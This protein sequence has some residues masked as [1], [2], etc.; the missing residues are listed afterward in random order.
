TQVVPGLLLARMI[1]RELPECHVDIGG[2]FFQRVREEL[3]ANPGFFREFTHSVIVGEGEIPLTGLVEALSHRKALKNVP[4]LLYLFRNK[5]AYTGE[6][7][8]QNLD[9]QAMP[10]LEGLPLE[11]YLTPEIILSIRASR[12][13][14]WNKCTFCDMFLG[15]RVDLLS[16]DRL[17]AEI[18]HLR[19]RYGIRRFY[20]I[21]E[22]I[23]PA[24]KKRMAARL[25]EEN[26]GI[27]WSANARTEKVFTLPVMQLFHDSGLRLLLWGLESGSR[28]IM[29]LINKGVDLDGRLDI[30]RNSAQAGI[31]NFG[32]IF[33]GFPSETREEAEETIRVICGNTDIIHGYGRSVFTLGKQSILK[34]RAQEYGVADVVRND[35]AFS[36]DLSYETSRGMTREEVLQIARSCSE[37][38]SKAYEDPL[39]MLLRHREYLLLYLSHHGIEYVRNYR[40][41]ETEVAQ[42]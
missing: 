34:D 8:R 33:F 2:N 14:Y 29:E 39:W 35:E 10:D 36:A 1:R 32:Y 4:G 27:T 11:K 12:G 28:R 18:R 9:D 20:F 5:V 13:C 22:C 25:V 6:G 26:L 41:P 30:L 40:L 31:F 21:D 15:E 17:V 37:I 19:D 38:C 23:P 16:P 42:S 7:P 24:H 3:C